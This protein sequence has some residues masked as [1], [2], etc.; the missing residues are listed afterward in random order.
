[1]TSTRRGC[2]NQD[3]AVQMS[4]VDLGP[5]PGR[6]YEAGHSRWSIIL[7]GAMYPPD[8]PLLWFSREAALAAGFNVLAV[9]DTFD[10]QGD[11]RAWV[12]TRLDAALAQVPDEAPLLITKSLTS[13][14]SRAAAA[15]E[16]P[17]VW[18]TPLVA[19]AYPA[20]P[21]VMEGLAAGHAPCLLVGGG[22]DS[23]WDAAVARMVPQST[24][25]EIADADHV[26]QVPGNLAR[27]L[28]ALRTVATAVH[29][30]AR[31]RLAS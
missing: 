31:E 22:A 24:I 16:L 1:M 19:A 12:E 17:G 20:A 18:L 3:M 4:E 8:A 2:H 6:R 25:V 7:P 23:S 30:F 9:W 27:S 5:C 15:R 28:E 13:L 11:P 14:A 21:Q 29:A 10:R 26:L